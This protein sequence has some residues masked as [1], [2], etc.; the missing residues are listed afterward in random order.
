MEGILPLTMRAYATPRGSGPLPT[1]TLP[2]LTPHSV[3][4][5]PAQDP[6]RDPIA[7][8][9]AHAP[10]LCAPELGALVVGS[11]ALAI[12]CER[13]GI[14][15]PQPK[16]L[17]FAW[18]LA[19][20]EGR[21]LLESHR[22]FVPTTT[23]S[24]DRGTLALRIG[25]LRCEITT[26]RDSDASMPIAMRIERDLRARDMTCG[27]VALSLHDGAIHDPCGGVADW[28]A[29]RVAACGDAEQRVREHPI[30][31]L[32]YFR[33]AR[34]WGFDVDSK[35][36]KLR[37]PLSVFDSLPKEAIALE[38]RAA[39][40][41]CASPGR[42]FLDLFEVG[43][44]D[45]LLPELALQFDGRPAGPQ[46]WHPEISQSLHIILALEWAVQHAQGLDER[47]RLAVLIAVLC[48]DLGK[49]YTRPSDLPSHPGH[50]HTGLAPLSAMLDRWPGLA[51]ARARSLAQKVCELHQ[52]ARR[53][54]EL[55]HG[56][57][58]SL[59]DTAFRGKDAQL[60]LFALAVA[61]DAAGRLGEEGCGEPT[62]V[63]VL[64]DLRRLCA[65][66][67]SVDAG[68]LRQQFADLDA[69]KA[70]LHEA[71]ARAV[72]AGF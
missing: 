62:R 5:P 63:K 50:E 52:L 54:E 8:V 10:W 46:R 47:D 19:P 4:A 28:R 21:A 35:I 72:A 17:D 70:A 51:D 24:V 43:L 26:L 49:G 31:W 12:A 71:R 40:L 11:Q 33:K 23:G 61:A 18:A 29:R 45:R 68:A 22:A 30:R 69:F 37:L 2:I 7:Y 48:H 64:E 13:E 58:A 14:A 38:L 16:D 15:G 36:R 25:D 59:Y 1:A 65:C 3:T 34:E 6:A 9:R 60:E 66:C 44:L 42:F 32:R 39:L 41:H 55:R 57:L 27:A 67:E 20:E 53:L 56:T